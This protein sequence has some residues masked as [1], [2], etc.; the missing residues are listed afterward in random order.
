MIDPWGWHEIEASKTEEIRKKLIDF[1]RKTWNEI[2]IREN[3][4][5]HRIAKAKIITA[6]Q[7]KLAEICQDDIDYLVSLRLSSRERI[8][9]IPDRG[10]LRLLWWDPYHQIC[11]S[12]K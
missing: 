12:S 7:E 1:E 4:W 2:L 10:V 9:G 3:H 6:A 8:W 5:N 11:P